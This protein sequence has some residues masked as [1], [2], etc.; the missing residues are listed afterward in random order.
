M[1]DLNDLYVGTWHP[2]APDFLNNLPM[3][4]LKEKRF[5]EAQ[6]IY[7]DSL[8]IMMSNLGPNHINVANTLTNMGKFYRKMGN[9]AKA[10]E[11][12]EKAK[13][14]RQKAILADR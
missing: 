11:M 13:I 12:E 4:Y 1:M 10:E 5:S 3:L 7:E 14:I 2:D 6:N 8:E 9:R